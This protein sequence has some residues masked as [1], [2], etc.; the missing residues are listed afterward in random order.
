MLTKIKA[1]VLDWIGIG[2]LNRRIDELEAENLALRTGAAVVTPDGKVAKAE[3]PPRP[4]SRPRIRSFSQ[5][6][7][8]REA[9][10]W[11]DLC[12]EAFPNANATEKRPS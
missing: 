9:Q 6:A 2:A 5:Y 8:Q 11:R 12:D 7:R 10:A 4:Q 1:K 3:P